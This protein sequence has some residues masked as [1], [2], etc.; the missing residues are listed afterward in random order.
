MSGTGNIFSGVMPNRTAEVFTTL[1]SERGI[2]IERIVSAGQGTRPGLWL[3]Q[4][5]GEWVLLLEGGAALEIEGENAM[6]QLG[7][8]D[9]VWLPPHRRHRV[10]WTDAGRTTVWLAV[11]VGP[12]PI[13]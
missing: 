2:R 8:G 12:A 11:H 1:L 7:P 9:Y 3:D 4:P 10:A 6:H 5:Q 13:T